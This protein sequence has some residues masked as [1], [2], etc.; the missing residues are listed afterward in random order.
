MS[1]LPVAIVS[2]LQPFACLF[3]QPTWRQAQVLLVGMLLAQGPRTVTAA[4]RVMGLGAERRFERYHRVLKRGAPVGPLALPVARFCQ[5]C[6][7]PCAPANPAPQAALPTGPQSGCF[8]S[9]ALQTGIQATG[10]SFSH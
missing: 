8:R 1:P 3:T 7:S 2:V 6:A 4:L 5:R 9:P 10:N